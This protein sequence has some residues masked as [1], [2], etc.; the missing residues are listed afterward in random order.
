MFNVALLGVKSMPRNKGTTKHGKHHPQKYVRGNWRKTYFHMKNRLRTNLRS[1]DM[2]L[3]SVINCLFLLKDEPKTWIELR[4]S[5][6]FFSWKHLY[7]T[8]Q[9]CKRAGL[10]VKDHREWFE[11]DVNLGRR[12]FLDW[13][14]ITSLGINFLKFYNNDEHR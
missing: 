13:W 11:Y 10:V 4:D 3:V 5:G 2:K 6:A 12:R 9:V 1:L 7:K 14:C 8:V